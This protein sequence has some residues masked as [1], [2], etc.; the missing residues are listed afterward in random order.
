MESNK[1]RRQEGDGWIKKEK[2]HILSRLS[3]HIHFK[4][5]LSS[6][7]DMW[8]FSVKLS[9]SRWLLASVS[10]C[11]WHLV[12]R[13]FAVEIKRWP[14]NTL[15]AE[16]QGQTL[17]WGKKKIE[18]LYI[19]KSCFPHAAN[20]THMQWHS[21]SS[22][23]RKSDSWFVVICALFVCW[24]IPLCICCLLSYPLLSLAPVP[25]F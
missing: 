24:I 16:V 5:A 6:S 12:T 14:K 20:F 21:R 13:A 15:L 25:L 23:K 19:K 8:R 1:V 2:G 7:P 17:C 11:C 4:N 10:V 9:R 22:Y 18:D 3:A